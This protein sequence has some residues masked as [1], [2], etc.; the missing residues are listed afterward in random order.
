MKKADYPRLLAINLAI[1]AVVLGCGLLLV[2][3]AAALMRGSDGGSSLL[4]RVWARVRGEATEPQG[5]SKEFKPPE[6]LR[7]RYIVSPA[8]IE[9]LIPSLR[10]GGVI[11]GNTPYRDLVTP[12][13][14]LTYIDPEQGKCLKPNL[15]FQAWFLR[16][17]IFS[18]HQMP[19]FSMREGSPA[20]SDPRVR[21]FLERYGFG[22]AR[23]RTDA[24]GDRITV[25]ESDKEEIVLVLGDSVAMCVMLSDDQTLASHLQ[26]TRN[27]ARYITSGVPSCDGRDS[28][29]RLE[30]RLRVYGDRIRGVIYTYCTNDLKEPPEDI[31]NKLADI[32]DR[33]QIR[34]RIFLHQDQF[35][36][37][38]PELMRQKV[39]L[40]DAE[41]KQG[42]LRLAKARGFEVI[43]S[44]L[45]VKEFQRSEGSLYAALALYVDHGHMSPR[46][47]RWLAEHLPHFS[48]SK[49]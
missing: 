17:L 18:P 21:E 46:G 2:E 23:C 5:G 26:Q 13:A 19:T 42:I 15:N 30:N 24:N 10:R 31:V 20:A 28:R 11:L 43:D 41:I 44:E 47:V 49:P 7:D 27:D 38:F 45:L 4:S 8:Q 39:R 22:P 16:S 29:K 37:T 14:S 35:Q 33:H 6:F 34:Y 25:P 36:N 9:E 48:K 12:E 32:L 3:G 40:K 1:F